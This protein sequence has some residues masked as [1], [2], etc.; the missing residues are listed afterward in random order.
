MIKT[1]GLHII[2][3][4]LR[5]GLWFLPFLAGALSKV[6]ILL[7]F[8]LYS[9]ATAKAVFLWGIL[10]S[11]FV[12]PLLFIFSLL[13]MLWLKLDSWPGF[14]LVWILATGILALLD[15]SLFKRYIAPNRLW[16]YSVSA[17]L[18]AIPVVF[19]LFSFLQ[20]LIMGPY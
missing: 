10:E 19:F 13:N 14:I 12:V 1:P 9:R 15:H 7:V 16:F 8:K 5:V 6:L 2:L 20:I 18:I 4:I 3:I 11:I 17:N